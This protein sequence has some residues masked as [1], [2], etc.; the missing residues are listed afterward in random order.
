M[1]SPLVALTLLAAGCAS[2]PPP[3]P[4]PRVAAPPSVAARPAPVQLAAPGSEQVS[5]A[6]ASTPLSTALAVLGSQ[7]GWNLVLAPGVD[8]QVDLVLRDV[9]WRLALDLILERTKCEAQR[10]GERVLY[11]HQPPRVTIQ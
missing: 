10:R 8:E 2:A 7:V 5:V 9:P 4:S 3:T 1:R 11:V 6:F